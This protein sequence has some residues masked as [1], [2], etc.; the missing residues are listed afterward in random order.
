MNTKS[1]VSPPR[2]RLLQAAGWL[3][4]GGAATG[5]GLWWQQRH[6]TPAPSGL[7]D[8]FWSLRFDQPQGG[9]LTLASL[10]GRPLLLNFWATWCPPCVKELP[11]LASFWQEF[12]R[13]DGQV[14]GLAVDSPSSVQRFLREQFAIPFPVG[15]AGLSGTQLSQSLGNAEGG[16][17]F[18]V[19][20]NA[21]GTI[22]Q[23]HRG[24]TTLHQLQAWAQSLKA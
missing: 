20:I 19:L 10:R 16:L 14:V 6:A 7:G 8:D 23:S 22:V 24:A 12:Q 17:P 5:A 9:E 1:P 15:L 3:A 4:V 11:E 13:N 21:Q 18:T 2:R